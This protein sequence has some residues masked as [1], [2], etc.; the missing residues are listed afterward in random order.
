MHQGNK[1][2]EKNLATSCAKIDYN[3]VW[4]SKALAGRVLAI[5]PKTRDF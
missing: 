2:K 1:R 5:T 3:E 4:K